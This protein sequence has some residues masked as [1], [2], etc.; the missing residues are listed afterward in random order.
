[1]MIRRPSLID[2]LVIAS[3]LLVVLSDLY[4]PK[5]KPLFWGFLILSGLA[6]AL[7]AFKLL[8]QVLSGVSNHASKKLAI[9]SSD[10]SSDI[11]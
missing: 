11:P 4:D 7:R 6:L 8:H 3:A 2:L 9:S 10:H 1:V 5:N